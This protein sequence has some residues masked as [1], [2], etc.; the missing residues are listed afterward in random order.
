MHPQCIES[1]DETRKHAYLFLVQDTACSWDGLSGAEC[2]H[3]VTSCDLSLQD[4]SSFILQA[5]LFPLLLLPSLFFSASPKNVYGQY[6]HG[7][8]SEDKLACSLPT[9]QQELAGSVSGPSTN[10]S[11]RV[12][13]CKELLCRMYCRT[14]ES[15]HVSSKLNTNAP[16]FNKTGNLQNNP[17]LVFCGCCICA[18]FECHSSFQLSYGRPHPKHPLPCQEND[19]HFPINT[20]LIL[21]ASSRFVP[22]AHASN[23]I[24]S[25][26]FARTQKALLATLEDNVL[27]FL[28]GMIYRI[29]Y[30]GMVK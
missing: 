13:C 26:Y 9:F 20:F 10:S 23:P 6:P 15:S 28:V 17:I 14:F 7:R 18:V 25:E 16:K 29:N 3:T 24:T 8:M 30:N 27:K 22:S 1:H 21:L 11:S 5:P 12:S 2:R 4:L 19:R